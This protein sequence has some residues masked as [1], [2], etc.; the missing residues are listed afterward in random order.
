MG[1]RGHGRNGCGLGKVGSQRG[2]TGITTVSGGLEVEGSEKG[3]GCGRVVLADPVS[4][5]G[6]ATLVEAV[7]LLT[8]QGAL[9]GCLHHKGCD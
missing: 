8:T 1:G 6:I 2:L 3:S 5:E 9:Q 4:A 7:V